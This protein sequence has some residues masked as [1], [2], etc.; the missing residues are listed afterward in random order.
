M[1]TELLKIKTIIKTINP[2]GLVIKKMILTFD[3]LASLLFLIKLCY[4]TYYS[5]SVVK[6]EFI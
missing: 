3:E 4:E 1:Y 2:S 6:V 5:E